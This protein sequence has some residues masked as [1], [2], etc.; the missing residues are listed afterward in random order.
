MRKVNFKF[1]A[2]WWL[3]WSE[4]DALGGATPPPANCPCFGND[5]HDLESVVTIWKPLGMY[6]KK[7]KEIHVYNSKMN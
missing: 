3:R 2:V 5:L 7:S 4:A 1:R 6:E